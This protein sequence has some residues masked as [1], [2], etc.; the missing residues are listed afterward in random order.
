M[1]RPRTECEVKVRGRLDLAALLNLGAELLG[2]GMQKDVYLAGQRTSRIRDENGQLTLTHKDDDVG[3]TARVKPVSSQVL[4][5]AEADQLIK[6]RGIRALV[7]KQRTWVCLDGAV[8]RLDDVEHLGQFVEISA[9]DEAGLSHTLAVLGIDQSKVIKHCYLD[10]MI[11]RSLPRWIQLVLRFHDRVGELAFGITSGILT[12]VGVLVGV[13]SATS[14]QLSVIASLVAI[15]IADS[16]SDA[17]G[18]YLSK[19][20]E[21][22]APRRLA[23]RYALGTLAGKAFFPLTFIVPLLVLPLATAVWLDLGWG[24]LALALLSA[25]QAV[26]EQQPIGRRVGRNL[27]LA[28]IIV[29]N[30]MLG[31]LLVASFR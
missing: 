9:R 17:F 28:V 13:N 22:G 19:V 27:G 26:V 25:E 18:M 4:S 30:S 14:S 23:L 12:T 8:I 15:A 31:G 5:Q 24:A 3:K 2:Q 20:S 6:D 21:R 10:L 29:V 7:C 11:A 1:G 16:C